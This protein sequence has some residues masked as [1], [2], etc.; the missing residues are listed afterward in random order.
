MKLF[1][2][3]VLV[4]YIG[5]VVLSYSGL[6]AS[7]YAFAQRLCRKYPT[8]CSRSETL[9]NLR[10]ARI[11]NVCTSIVPVGNIVVAAVVSLG[12]YV[13]VGSYHGLRYRGVDEADF[14]FQRD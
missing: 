8:V 1:T 10:R 11:A 13:S 12:F 5:S 3:C 9:E 7:D 6:W 4:A 2:A 14:A